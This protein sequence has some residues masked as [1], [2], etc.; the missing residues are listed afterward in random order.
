[1]PVVMMLKDTARATNAFKKFSSF[2]AP[3][4]L[5]RTLK[6]ELKYISATADANAAVQIR[7]GNA[8]TRRLPL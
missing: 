1:M 2:V 4:R 5:V 3:A 8:M 7:D 6:V